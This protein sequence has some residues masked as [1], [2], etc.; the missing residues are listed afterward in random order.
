MSQR[1]NK[2]VYYHL[3]G[4]FEF[5]ELYCAFLPLYKE[6]REYSFMT[7]VRSVPSMALL[8]IVSGEADA[9]DLDLIIQKKS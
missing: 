9:Q 3:P 4:L 1:K 2:K 5:Y 8:Q 6:H 7:G